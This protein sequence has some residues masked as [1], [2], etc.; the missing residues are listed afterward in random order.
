MVHSWQVSEA[1]MD[2]GLEWLGLAQEVIFHSPCPY[3]T[4]L[5]FLLAPLLLRG[6]VIK[7]LFQ[8]ERSF[9]VLPQPRLSASPPWS[10]KRDIRFPSDFITV[11][12]GMMVLL[13]V[14]GYLFTMLLICIS[15]MT[16]DAKDL[17]HMRIIHLHV[18]FGGMTAQLH[19]LLW[20]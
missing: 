13:G 20:N 4:T 11:P 7:D 5:T 1:T 6:A 8:A 12:L 18:L 9:S 19:C 14:E 3:F 2:L 17:F 10:G 15:Q 16:K